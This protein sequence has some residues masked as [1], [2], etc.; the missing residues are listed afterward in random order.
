MMTLG[1]TRGLRTPLPEVLQILYGYI[2][3]SEVEKRIEQH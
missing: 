2:I 3:T 1:M